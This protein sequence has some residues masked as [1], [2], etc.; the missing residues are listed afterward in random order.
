M[1]QALQNTILAPAVAA[2]TLLF[3][4]VVRIGSMGVTQ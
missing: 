1:N 3:V 2:A 4:L